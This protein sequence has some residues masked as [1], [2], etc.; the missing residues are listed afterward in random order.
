MPLVRF[1]HNVSFHLPPTFS[2]FSPFDT[3]YSIRNRFSALVFRTGGCDVTAELQR[4]RISRSDVVLRNA[5]KSLTHVKGSDA[6]TWRLSA[7]SW[8][9]MKYNLQRLLNLR[10]FPKLW[11][12]VSLTIPGKLYWYHCLLVVFLRKNSCSEMKFSFL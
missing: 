7:L 8:L 10:I 9:F 3:N 6:V 2:P 4:L 5:T 12:N 1:T 11:L